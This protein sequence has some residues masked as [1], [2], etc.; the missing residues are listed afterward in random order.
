[1]ELV[2][3]LYE[4]APN[5]D[6]LFALSPNTDNPYL[7]YP[8]SS[9]KGGVQIVNTANKVEREREVCKNV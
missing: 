6:G 4:I 5:E 9:T 1:M 2:Q 3:R 7:A 8:A